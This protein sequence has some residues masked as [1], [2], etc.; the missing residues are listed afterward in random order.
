MHIE[1]S[2]RETAASRNIRQPLKADE[3]AFETFPPSDT[4]QSPLPLNASY[5]ISAPA[6][7][8]AKSKE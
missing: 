7:S 1:R 3:P 2:G 8:E 5:P 6:A 4:E